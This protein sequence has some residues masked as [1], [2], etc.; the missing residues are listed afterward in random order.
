MSCEVYYFSGAYSPNLKRELNCDQ[1]FS[2]YHEP[3]LV[4]DTL[5]YAQEHPEYTAKIMLD[6][7]AFTH[8]QVLKKKGIELTDTE[9]YEYT[10]RYLEFLNEHGEGLTCF[11]G[12]DSVP[13]PTNVD[14]TYADK[15]WENYLYMWNKLKPSIRHKLIPVFH[16]GEDWKHLER[17][18]EYVH[19]DGSK[20]DY[21]GLAISLE[22]TKKVRI[23]WGQQAMKIIAASSNPNVKTHA[24]G[25]GVK[26]VLEHIDVYS[27][28]ATSWVKR[29]AY[30]MISINDKTIYIS[31]IQKDKLTGNHYSERS[32][33]YQTEVE[34]AI[35]DRGFKVDPEKVTYTV[36]NDV[37][38][39]VTSKGTMEARFNGTSL[40]V[41]GEDYTLES[42]LVYDDGLARDP[43]TGIWEHE[44]KI[45]KFDGMSCL[46]GVGTVEYDDG[47]CLAT[48]CYARARFNILDTEEWMK[49]IRQ[50]VVG[51]VA[52]K[53]DLW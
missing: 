27:T 14:H 26:S 18:L 47:R 48:N 37:A 25:V 17:F 13:D 33:A 51:K 1:L 31:D 6:S 44:E 29:A 45:L 34:T 52:T 7:G 39:F 42:H 35:K 36:D 4:I 30:G 28:D 46:N 41:N 9:I 10:D 19:E 11:V 5:K 2:Y 49:E 32:V 22:G 20:L 40:N 3:K 16:Y 21:I 50:S 24:F 12:V 23:D 8:Y 43:F 15:T 38:T 53:V